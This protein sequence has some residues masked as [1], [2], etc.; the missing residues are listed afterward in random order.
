MLLGKVASQCKSVVSAECL[1]VNR[2]S[3][4]DGTLRSMKCKACPLSS[5]Q[6]GGSC[7]LMSYSGDYSKPRIDHCVLPS[8]YFVSCQ[9]FIELFVKRT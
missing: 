7:V 4:G 6:V 8:A 3:L 9:G 1:V 5:A 2:T